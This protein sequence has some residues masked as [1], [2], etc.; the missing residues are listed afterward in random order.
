MYIHVYARVYNT[1]DSLTRYVVLSRT[2]SSESFL[3]SSNKA[4]TIQFTTFTYI[5]FQDIICLCCCGVSYRPKGKRGRWEGSE[6]TVLYSDVRT[7]HRCIN[8]SRNRNFVLADQLANRR[9]Q[10]DALWA[11]HRQINITAIRLLHSM[12]RSK[13]MK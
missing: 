12:I 9:E 3:V 1:Y 4:A 7:N 11:Q 13:M 10:I 2:Y 8:S 6:T 5:R